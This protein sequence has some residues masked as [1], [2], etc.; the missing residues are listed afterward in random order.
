[1][2]LMSSVAKER[3]PIP[4][5]IAADTLFRQDH[6]CCVCRE[7]GR[8]VQI[9]HMDDDP[10]NHTSENL[11][12][13]CLIDHEQ[14]QIRGGFGR[15]LLA[16]E[17]RKYRDDWLRRVEFRRSEADKVA[18]T[19][20]AGLQL[21]PATTLSEAARLEIPSEQ[22]L[23]AYVEGLPVTLGK[24]YERAQDLWDTGV[25]ANMLQGNYDVI[26]VTEKIWSHLATWF[27]EKHFGNRP[28][29]QYFS[30]FVSQR[31]EWY[32]AVNEPGGVG[33]GGTI[34]GVMAGGSVRRD[35]EEA[36]EDTVRGLLSDVDQFSFRNWQ[37]RWRGAAG[38]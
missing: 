11:A 14:T 16:E 8:P 21:L 9:H 19:S 26:D 34:I 33:T 4:S 23:C 30:E 29:D 12:V 10:S 35:V 6:T 22:A 38:R 3:T 17:V 15:K 24:A 5:E 31:F 27:P 1:M 37:K 13:L 20:M 18:A 32:R 25:T 7:K 36:I 28:A 2:N